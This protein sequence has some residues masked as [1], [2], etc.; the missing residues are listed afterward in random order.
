MQTLAAAQYTAQRVLDFVCYTHNIMWEAHI[1]D[2][3]EFCRHIRKAGL[4]LAEFARLLGVK[5]NSV[6]SYASKR[7]VPTTYAIIAVFLGEAG[8]KHVDFRELLA[9]HDALPTLDAGN[10]PDL[11]VYR[12][13]KRGPTT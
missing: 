12:A 5:A 2:Y 8:D 11:A 13:R 3:P 9:S 10:V 1:L 4:S 7:S 6:T